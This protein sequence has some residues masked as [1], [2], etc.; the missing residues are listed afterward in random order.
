MKDIE[1]R[2]WVQHEDW[3]APIYKAG[4]QSDTFAAAQITWYP[5]ANKSF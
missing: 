4:G 3:K 5:K 1:I 2:G